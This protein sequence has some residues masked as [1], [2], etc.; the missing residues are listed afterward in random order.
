MAE[1]AVASADESDDNVMSLLEADSAAAVDERAAS[2]D[3][4]A[5]VFAVDVS[6]F[7]VD[8]YVF[9]LALTT[10]LRTSIVGI[11]MQSVSFKCAST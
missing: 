9:E 4:T 1:L 2:D 5:A 3:D 10:G 11:P 6:E 8:E 7:D